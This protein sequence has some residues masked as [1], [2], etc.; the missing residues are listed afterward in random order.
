M[1][2]ILQGFGFLFEKVRGLNPLGLVCFKS[3]TSELYTKGVDSPHFFYVY[4]FCSSSST[5]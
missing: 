1:K 3:G 5:G 2:N 4:F